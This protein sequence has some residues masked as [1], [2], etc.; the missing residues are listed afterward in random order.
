MRYRTYGS[1]RADA[2]SPLLRRRLR[3]PPIRQ[4]AA[5]LLPNGRVT[6]AGALFQARA[7]EDCNAATPA[8]NETEFLQPVCCLRHAFTS[9]PKHVG[10]HLLRDRDVVALRAIQAQQQP[11]AQSLVQ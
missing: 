8:S 4:Q 2:S 11:A 6:L 9:H 10:N 3:R 7:I 1:E 5:I